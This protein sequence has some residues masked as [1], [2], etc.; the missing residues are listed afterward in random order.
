M[1]RIFLWGVAGLRFAG[2]GDAGVRVGVLMFSLV[3]RGV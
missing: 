1:I 3:L 2:A